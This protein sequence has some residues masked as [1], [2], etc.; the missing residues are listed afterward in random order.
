MKEIL[1]SHC[2]QKQVVRIKAPA[3]GSIQMKL[4]SIRCKGCSG[5]FE[6]MIPGQITAG[7]FLAWQWPLP[8]FLQAPRPY[9]HYI[10]SVS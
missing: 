8:S 10:R 6:D 3:I 7:P 2:N 9:G 1:C 5:V 4:Q